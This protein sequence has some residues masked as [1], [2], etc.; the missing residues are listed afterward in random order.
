MNNPV[1]IWRSVF[2]DRKLGQISTWKK[3]SCIGAAICALLASGATGCRTASS[4]HANVPRIITL[5]PSAT[6]IVEALGATPWLVGV[7]NY[8]TFPPQV[9]L[10][11]NV[12]SY[13]APNLETIIRLRPSLVI[14]DDVHSMQSAALHDRGVATIPCAIH[15][16]QDVKTGL[17]SV[18]AQI[19]KQ[20]EAAAAIGGIDA[21][22]DDHAAAKP[23]HHPRVLAVIDRETHGLGNLVAAGPG[24][25]VDEL[26][27][28]VGGD[29]ALS[30]AGTRYPKISTE[31]VLRTQPDIILDLS[32]AG[33]T[34]LAP[35]AS[36]DVPAVRTKRVIANSDPYIIAPS[37]RIAAALA[38]LATIV[39]EF[40]GTVVV[41]PTVDLWHQRR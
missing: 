40:D 4:D 11:P 36:L 3:R 22:L 34:S 13:I 30:A 29:N 9:M 41:D 19:G 26:L 25:W 33:R 21:A 5:S 8:S 12:G 20:A 35:W 17:A 10:L 1:E 28:V 7:D 27:A 14:V 24:S 2:T 23:A 18:G 16:I 37:P 6:E 38:R 31:E 39:L 32:Q 15:G